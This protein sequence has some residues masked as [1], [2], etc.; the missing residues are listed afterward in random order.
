MIAAV[1]LTT[2]SATGTSSDVNA[3]ENL[4]RQW[5]ELRTNISSE[6]QAWKTQRKQLQQSIALL[7][8]ETEE[9]DR[10]LANYRKQQD[11]QSDH[12]TRQR[13]RKAIL[14]N[15]LAR[16]DAIA[17]NTIHEIQLIIPQIPEP[18]RSE[19]MRT[20]LL[21]DNQAT[22]LQRIQI[23]TAVMGEINHLENQVHCVKELIEINGQRR[24]MDVVYL[25]LARGFAVSDD[26]STA[27]VGMP[28]PAGWR[29]QATPNHASTIRKM[30]DI[31]KNNIT[32]QLVSIRLNGKTARKINNE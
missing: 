15:Q 26:N 21:N 16:T 22:T 29:W 13:Q 2:L 25:G 28:F 14:E 12:V 20:L 18:I 9:L 27:A 31:A 5:V 17:T 19:S 1:A 24:A 10:I 3:L 30:V 7:T 11:S 23:L 6:Q 4:V 8:R 32:P